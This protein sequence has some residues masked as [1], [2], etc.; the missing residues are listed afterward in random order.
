MKRNICRIVV[1]YHF[2]K[3]LH[4]QNLCLGLLLFFCIILIRFDFLFYNFFVALL[5]C[6]LNCKN[7][8]VIAFRF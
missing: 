6:D 3:R 5:F 2:Y 4:E 7:L 8:L 1:Q